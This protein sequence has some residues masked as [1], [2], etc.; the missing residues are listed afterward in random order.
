V[1]EQQ[2]LTTTD[3]DAMLRYLRGKASERK[4]RLFACACCRRLRDFLATDARG[5]CSV[6][7]KKGRFV[8]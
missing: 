2:W 1:G 3:P 8:P 4:L 5:T 6:P 7:E